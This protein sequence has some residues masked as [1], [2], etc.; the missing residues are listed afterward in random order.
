MGL[1]LE[2]LMHVRVT[3][4][5]KKEQSVANSAAAIFVITS[6]DLRRSG[7]TSIPEALRMVP[8][9]EV[10]RIN[11]NSWAVTSR[12]FNGLFANKLL[13]LIDGRSVYTPF[14]AGVNWEMQDTLLE[15]IDR[16]EVIRGPGATIWGA[17][18]VNGVIN[19]ITRSAHDTT[20]TLLS[21]G[22]G[23]YEKAFAGARYGTTLGDDG[24]L[25]IYA[26]YQ[27]RGESEVKGSGVGGE[28]AWE[29]ARGG[30][31]YDSSLNGRDT[32]TLQGDLHG[33]RIDDTETLI[34]LN[35]IGSTTVTPGISFVGS[36]LL[37]RFQ[38]TFSDASDIY[39]QLYYDHTARYMAVLDEKHDT[40]DLELQHR[41]PLGSAQEIIW[42]A[43]YRFNHDRFSNKEAGLK[44]SPASRGD[45]LYSVFL[46]DDITLYPERLHLIVGTKLEHND[47]SGI[48]VQPSGRI[49][50]TPDD[51]HT[52]WGAVSRAVR[53]PSRADTTLYNNASV[54]PA[55]GPGSSPT[56]LSVVGSPSFGAEGVVAYEA[57]YRAELAQT[58][59]LDL[60][61]FY[62]RYHD[63]GDRERGF[64]PAMAPQQRNPYNTILLTAANGTR[65]TSYGAE[66]SGEWRPV[67]RWKVK[68][69]YTFI[70]LQAES[71]HDPRGAGNL[72]D[73][74]PAQQFSLRSMTDLG[75]DLSLDLWGRYVDGISRALP[76][77]RGV[78]IPSYVG[79]DVRLSWRVLPG[80]ELTAVGQNLVEG[81]H[82]EFSSET[83]QAVYLMGRSFYGK[84][85]WEF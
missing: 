68:G 31:R 33:G 53:T 78:A 7:A 49:L 69:A 81:A 60:A 55:T 12:G 32:V 15:D 5:S 76:N 18:A 17:N 57:G 61:T 30:F 40:I 82:E 59:S 14:F 4:V 10:A 45:S 56:L 1:T 34:S 24:A 66:L 71:S 77:S 2:D 23:N 27:N 42:G 8:G 13:V 25:R 70:N 79:L 74:V 47:Y 35:P 51:R 44:L 85:T 39:A 22:G 83:S 73:T 26:K 48:E 54:T 63:V 28:D 65:V 50:W 6:E 36:N 67:P 43:G 16:I 80:V 72:E 84:L 3:S 46:Q 20:G 52:V 19:I 37:G 64:I 21:A 29:T 41:F 58:F 75:R 11:S 62:N 9:L 38:R